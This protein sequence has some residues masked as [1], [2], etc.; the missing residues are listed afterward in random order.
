MPN[1]RISAESDSLVHKGAAPSKT[2]PH[3][4]RRLVGA[5]LALPPFH[6]IEELRGQGKPS[7]YELFAAPP[8]CTPIPE[9]LRGV[10]RFCATGILPVLGHGQDGHG[11][12]ALGAP[13]TFRV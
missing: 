10:Q 5:G 12:A 6:T 1:R 11:T 8:R 2:P 3:F 9:I 4:F 7:P 13:V